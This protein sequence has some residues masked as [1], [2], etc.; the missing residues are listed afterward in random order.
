MITLWLAVHSFLSWPFLKPHK[1]MPNL[2]YCDTVMEFQAGS[3][4]VA[5]IPVGVKGKGDLVEDNE[6]SCGTDVTLSQL[7]QD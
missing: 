7:C 1:K 3:R 6:L 2:R 5:L 4:I